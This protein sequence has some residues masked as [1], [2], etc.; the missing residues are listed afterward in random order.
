[1]EGL[2]RH[3]VLRE[4]AESAGR[5][6]RAY[7]LEESLR[8][9]FPLRHVVVVDTEIGSGEASQ[10]RDDEADDDAHLRLGRWGGRIA[11][12]CLRGD[13]DVIGTGGGRGPLYTVRNLQ[14]NRADYPGVVVSLTGKISATAWRGAPFLD[15]DVVARE[16]ASVLPV[17]ECRLIDKDIILPAGQ[18]NPIDTS[19][20]NFAIIGVGALGGGHRLV[21]FKEPREL[22]PVNS[23]LRRLN[24]TAKSLDKKISVVNELGAELEFHHH[25]VGDIC[26]RLFVCDASYL[27]LTTA[28]K[29]KLEELKEL[30]AKLNNRFLSPK[31]EQIRD[32]CRKGGV[33]AVCGGKHKVSPLLH[34][35]RRV[36]PVISHL[37]TDKW[38]AE[39]IV[40]LENQ[41]KG[42]SGHV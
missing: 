35:L 14:N 11:N 22:E 6:D 5:A 30:V 20:I 17:K 38:S 31:F 10:G 7:D 40:G 42:A 15:A 29:K 27:H 25:W 16:F 32:I 13:G 23:E 39:R 19:S 24:A 21:R 12:V 28:E 41:I 37:I 8:R 2:V 3:I 18:P 4:G 33:L 9:S 1:M 34:L 36:P 26:N